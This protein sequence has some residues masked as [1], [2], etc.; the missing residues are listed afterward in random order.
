MNSDEGVKNKGLRSYL[1]V[2]PAGIY[3]LGVKIGAPSLVW[4]MRARMPNY[5]KVTKE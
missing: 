2:N 3:R 1:D 5:S 4:T